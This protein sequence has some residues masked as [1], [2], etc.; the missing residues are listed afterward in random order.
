MSKNKKWEDK[1]NRY[2]GGDLDKLIAEKEKAMTTTTDGKYVAA[3]SA[4]VGNIEDGKLTKEQRNEA[5]R[6]LEI[7]KKIKE[8]LPKIANILEY[9]KALQKKLME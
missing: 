7:L 2:K 1:Y 5:K 6:S 9:R 8:N 3:R 4:G